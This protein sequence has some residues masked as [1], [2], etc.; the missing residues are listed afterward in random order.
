MNWNIFK[1]F[2]DR[3]FQDVTDTCSS[4][5]IYM[6]SHQQFQER[7]RK[8]LYY[9]KY[10][11]GTLPSPIVTDVAV[12]LINSKTS[13]KKSLDKQQASRITRRARIS[14]CALMMGILYTERLAQSNPS[15]LK[16]VSSSDLFMVSMLVASKYLYDDGEDDDA[17]NYD[18]CKAGNYH[19]RDLNRLE[20]EF[21]NSI[22][23]RIFVS[24]QE[25]FEFVN[26]VETRVAMDQAEKRGWCSYL[27][28]STLFENLMF[29]D[30]L[31]R[32]VKS[33]GKVILGCTLA[34]SLSVAILF[35]T[36][37]HVC[38]S[39]KGHTFTSQNTSTLD[40]KSMPPLSFIGQIGHSEYS[41]R[42]SQSVRKRPTKL[43]DNALEE[44]EYA[45]TLTRNETTEYSSIFN[46]D[47]CVNCGSSVLPLDKQGTFLAGRFGYEIPE[48]MSGVRCDTS[49]NDTTVDAQKLVTGFNRVLSFIKLPFH[50]RSWFY[51]S[52]QFP[53]WENMYSDILIGFKTSVASAAA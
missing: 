51:G 24:S 22:E 50:N 10:A 27:D 4:E 26:K 47:I 5:K 34:Y 37:V 43:Q 21:L 18:W 38:L 52:V 41:L 25:F 42:I 30:F 20:R 44:H 28:M 48:S 19:I 8:T 17:Y 39:S 45:S 23:W 2:T 36:P 33:M 1:I 15:Y 53:V 14:P 11:D 9:G 35:Y 16:K 12:R 40:A 31:A 6:E 32:Y 3:G 29:Q 46:Q 49:L 13:G 7:L